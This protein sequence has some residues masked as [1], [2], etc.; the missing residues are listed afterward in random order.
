MGS[1]G[2]G[3]FENDD[4]ADLIAELEGVELR[5]RAAI[6]AEALEGVVASGGY[7][8]V[9]QGNVA[10]AAAALVAGSRSARAVVIGGQPSA[11]VELTPAAPELLALAAEAIDRV[12]GA[13]SEW[14]ALWGDGRVLEEAKA[15]ARALRA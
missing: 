8:E 14:R 5:E 13:G 1:W 12:T 9:D 6:L 3:A 15:L 7:L 2:Q 11:S 10:V 4:A